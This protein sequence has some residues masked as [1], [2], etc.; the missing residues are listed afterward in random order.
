[1]NEYVI[2]LSKCK[3]IGNT[4]LSNFIKSNEFS[5]EKMKHNLSELI[6]S[7]DYNCFD[8]LLEEAKKEIETNA[9]EGSNIITMLDASFPKKLYECKDPVV[10]L[11]YKGNWDLI[12]KSKVAVI[13]S[14]KARENSLERTKKIKLQEEET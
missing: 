6:S 12:N 13:G 14:R 9:I 1:M 2:A 8:L 3:G 5:V 4:K 11:Y 7:S 10:Y